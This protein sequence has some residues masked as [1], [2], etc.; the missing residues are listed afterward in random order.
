MDT[1]STTEPVPVPISR[2]S[3][4]DPTPATPATTADALTA[5]VLRFTIKYRLNNAVATKTAT[6]FVGLTASNIVCAAR[7]VYIYSIP[8]RMAAT[9]RRSCLGANKSLAIYEIPLGTA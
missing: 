4:Q 8:R 9:F 3:G 2:Y 1:T 7:H 5:S 6:S